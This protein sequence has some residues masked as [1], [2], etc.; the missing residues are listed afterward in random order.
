MALRTDL[1]R[2]LGGFDERIFLYA[3]DADLTL[4]VNQVSR[5]VYVPD[6]MV[7]HEWQRSSYKKFGMFSKHLRSLAYYFRKWGLR[8]A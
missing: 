7:R 2:E 8:L 4:R 5:T 3:E 6:A 1:F